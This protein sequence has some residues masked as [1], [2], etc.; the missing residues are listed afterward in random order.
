[1]SELNRASCTEEEIVTEAPVEL[2]LG[3]SA[4]CLCRSELRRALQPACSRGR[5]PEMAIGPDRP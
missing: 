5:E 2:G 1:M 3:S 4:M